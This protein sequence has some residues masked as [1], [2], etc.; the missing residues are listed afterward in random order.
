[1]TNSTEIDK[2]IDDKLLDC[3]SVDELDEN[4][5]RQVMNP[6]R[7]EQLLAQAEAFSVVNSE[8]LDEF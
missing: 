4:D 3:G 5:I 7:L 8:A 6:E 1:M 2:A